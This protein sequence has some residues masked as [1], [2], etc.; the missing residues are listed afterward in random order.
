[1]GLH[2]HHQSH[3]KKR[4]SSSSARLIH[5]KIPATSSFLHDKND[6]IWNDTNE[7]DLLDVRKAPSISIMD[8]EHFLKVRPSIRRLYATF[9]SICP[10]RYRLHCSDSL[11][12]LQ[13]ITCLANEYLHLNS[14]SRLPLTD[15]VDN[16]ECLADLINR[17]KLLPFHQYHPERYPPSSKSALHC[18]GQGILP[19]DSNN[20][21]HQTTLFCFELITAIRTGLPLPIEIRILDPDER[22]VPNSVKHLNT[23]DQGQTKLYSCSYKPTTQAG[24]Y[25][26]SVL[27]NNVPLTNDPFTVCI[28]N[29]RMKKKSNPTEQQVASEETT[30]T[31]TMHTQGN[32]NDSLSRRILLSHRR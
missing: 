14:S 23:H 31:T 27:L 15:V 9:N 6:L 24:L 11:R 1:M 8:E 5:L 32:E 10:H 30:T 4:R 22:I 26:I 16:E 12:I 7:L 17:L 20:Q 18:F 3:S 29:A 21:L 2:P 13:E 28:R 25:K 19:L